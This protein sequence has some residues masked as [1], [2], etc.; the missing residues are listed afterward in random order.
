MLLDLF[1]PDAGALHAVDDSVV[2]SGQGLPAK[3]YKREPAAALFALGK[4]LEA[5][6]LFIVPDKVLDDFMLCRWV[7]GE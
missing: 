7:H 6:L 2:F 5:E 1:P 3:P 4:G